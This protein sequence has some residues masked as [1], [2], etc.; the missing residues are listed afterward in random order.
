[1]IPSF[2]MVEQR[3]KVEEKKILFEEPVQRAREAIIYSPSDFVDDGQSMVEGSQQ[4]PKTEFNFLLQKML[5]VIKEVVFANSVSF[6][7]QP[8]SPAACPRKQID[9]QPF[10]F[11]IKEIA[12]RQRY[13]QSDRFVRSAGDSESDCSQRGTGHCSVLH[14]PG[15]NKIVYRRA[16]FLSTPRRIICCRLRRSPSTVKQT[17]RTARKR[18]FSL[19]SLRKCF[20]RC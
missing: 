11:D 15:G 13:C 1:M 3:A 17:M 14:E 9:R 10:I 4:E 20:Q 16:C 12:D 5:S 8:R 2:V 6:L 19:R 18:L 7:G